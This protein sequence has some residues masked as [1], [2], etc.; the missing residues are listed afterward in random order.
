MGNEK[1]C[2]VLLISY[3]H[4]SY[5]RKCIESVLEQK[6]DYKFIIKIFDDASTDGSSDIIREYAEKYP[7]LISAYI[8]TKNMGAEENIW[9]AYKS[10]DTKYCILT[11]TDDYWC[12]ENKLQMQIQA[13]EEHPECCFCSTNS[14]IDTTNENIIG[15]K[16]KKIMVRLNSYQKE[17]NNFCDIKNLHY[18]F[19]PHVSSRLLKTEAIDLNE[20]KYKKCFLL[21][22][23]QFFFLLS[24]GPMFWIEDVTSVYNKTGNGVWV[25]QPTGKRLNMWLDAIVDF[26]KE[27]NN[28]YFEKLASQILI[29]LR[30]GLCVGSSNTKTTN[31]QNC[32]RKYFKII[33]QLILVAICNVLLF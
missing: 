4:K 1:I 22:Y 14:S 16:N 24:K 7:D 30:W 8:A 18:D 32:L 12:N 15:L 20:I 3:N 31:K 10:V 26:N 28:V 2:T 6:T 13:M 5:I 21:D 17:I 29:I 27:T 9:K 23:T 33:N 19:I 25:N 11:E